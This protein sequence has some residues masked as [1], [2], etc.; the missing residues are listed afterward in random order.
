MVQALTA[1]EW[2]AVR[3]LRQDYFFKSQPDPYIWTFDRKDHIHFAFYKNTDIIG[4]AHL[5]LWPHHRTALRI[6]VIDKLY[7]N[8]GYGSQFLKLCERW[9]THQGYHKLLVQASR[10]AYPFYAK[11]GYIEMPFD[12]P[13]GHPTDP[14]DTGMGKVLA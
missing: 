8:Q 5:Q 6:I 4:Y 9:L 7:R 10:T 11:N 12:D 2:A 3:R 1:R 13:D 14:N